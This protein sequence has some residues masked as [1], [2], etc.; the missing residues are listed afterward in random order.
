MM[1]WTDEPTLDYERY[2]EAQDARL[3]MLPRCSCCDEPIQDECAYY[4]N[5]EWVCTEC[6]ERDFRRAVPEV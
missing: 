5:D 6:M 4:I 1:M 2:M 3:E